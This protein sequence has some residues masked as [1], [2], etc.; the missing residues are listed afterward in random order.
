MKFQCPHCSHKYN[1]QTAIAGQKA[2][3]AKCGQSFSVVEASTATILTS[4]KGVPPQIDPAKAKPQATEL[5]C[6]KC[7]KGA[8]SVFHVADDNN[9]MCHPCYSELHKALTSRHIV[10]STPP[11]KTYIKVICSEFSCKP[12]WVLLS[13]INTPLFCTQCSKKLAT[14]PTGFFS[15][16]RS[17]R[18]YLASIHFLLWFCFWI[19]LISGIIVGIIALSNL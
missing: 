14:G 5:I 16:F 8:E 6:C 18:D 1:I 9:L 10:P 15:Y 11:E 12:N 4:E 3:C 7:Q 19:S 2:K 13:H 17:E